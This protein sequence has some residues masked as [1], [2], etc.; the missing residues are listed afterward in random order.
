[1]ETL[2]INVA[3]ADD[4]IADL[5]EG[6]N[7]GEA[8]YSFPTWEALHA[9]LTPNRVALLASLKGKGAVT[10]REAAR[11]VRRDFRPVHA[12]IAALL[13]VGILDRTPAGVIFPFK[14]L[15]IDVTGIALVA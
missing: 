1:M 6:K 14:D 12:D 11:L 15:H 7:V 2:R 8:I 5:T 10:M 9:T 13:K 4:I 3:T